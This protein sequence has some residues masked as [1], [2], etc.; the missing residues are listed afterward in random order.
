MTDRYFSATPMAVIVM[1]C[2]FL[3]PGNI[4]AGTG[5]Q[6]NDKALKN[7]R[8]KI[9]ATNERARK[10]EQEANIVTKEITGLRR[11]LVTAARKI[12]QVESD[13][14]EKEDH[15]YVLD[16][17]EKKLELTLKSR[18]G[19]MAKTL[20]AM[21][22]LSRQ[23]VELVAYRPDKAINSLRTASLL[24]N[25]QPEL[26]KRAT[27]IR[28]DMAEILVIRD[29]ITRERLELT[30]LL[31]LLTSEQIEMNRLLE[32]RRLKQ[33]EL[34]LATRQERRKLKQFAARAKTLQEL[35]AK[36]EQ[37]A[38]EREKAARAAAKRLA[39]KPDNKPDQKAAKSAR[40][41]LDSL[42]DGVVT[43]LKAKG[44]MPLPARG[45]I[46]RTFGAKT[47]EGQSSE[48]I[49]IH[50]R[51]LA[52]VVSPHEGRIVFAGK[53]RSYGQLLI[54]SHGQEYHTLLAGMTRLDAEVGQWV[55]KGE[56]IGQMARAP[57]TAKT[58][59]GKA[60]QLRT[61]QNLYVELRR[62]GKPINPLP[63]IMAS[64]RKVL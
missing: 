60:G 37:E 3:I 62:M 8:D 4:W 51:P 63:W 27:V 11:K 54:I 1:A 24:K 15:L 61:G 2:V 34:R 20:A 31:S 50:T 6:D 48:G 29:Q 16:L 49:T 10:Y 42:P 7:M 13:V 46:R 38:R 45:A 21:Q 26:K 59:K 64:D 9:T 17:Q 58:A 30:N 41:K 33:K 52:T 36:I 39:E 28:Q 56:P 18:Y 12:Q 40:L 53:F 19:Q 32:T 23:P 44:T 5:N 43:F 22:R 55:L 47:P 25:L 14:Y 35:I 57:D